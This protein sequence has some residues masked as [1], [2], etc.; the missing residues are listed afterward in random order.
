MIRRTDNNA[1][2]SFKKFDGPKKI[3]NEN[4][5]FLDNLFVLYQYYVDVP[6]PYCTDYQVEN[7][8]HHVVT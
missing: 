8:L 6:V 2:D 1:I 5:I 3:A 4:N 7:N